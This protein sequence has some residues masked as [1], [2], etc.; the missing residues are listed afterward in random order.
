MWWIEERTPRLLITLIYYVFRYPFWR[1]QHP[2][3]HL[4]KGV[5]VKSLMGRLFCEFVT[6]SN[7]RVLI[8]ETI[9]PVGYRDIAGS[10]YASHYRREPFNFIHLLRLR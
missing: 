9:R 2:R 4:E 10:I 1:M 5:V 3:E 7:C 8:N 6:H